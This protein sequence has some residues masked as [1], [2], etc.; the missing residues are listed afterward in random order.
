VP[1]SQLAIEELQNPRQSFAEEQEVPLKVIEFD[2]NQKKIV[3]SVRDYLRDK[4][5]AEYEAY[6][7][8]H[9]IQEYTIGDAVADSDDEMESWGDALEGRPAAAVVAAGDAGDEGDES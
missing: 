3:L 7:A 9:P 1:L 2:E 6:L 4:D 5:Q 8:S